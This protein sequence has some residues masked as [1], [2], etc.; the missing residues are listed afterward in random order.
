MTLTEAQAKEWVSHMI[1]ADGTSG[2]HWTVEKTEIV[3]NQRGVQWDK[4]EWYAALNMIYSD[5]SEVFR[6]YGVRDQIFLYADMAQAFLED[7]NAAPGK[8]SHYCES[9]VKKPEKT[10]F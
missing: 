10:S 6:R 4:F 8:L 5:Y 3:K 9:I 2:P 1:N 7:K